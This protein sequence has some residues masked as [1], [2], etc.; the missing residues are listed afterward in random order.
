[1]KRPRHLLL[2]AALVVAAVSRL[3][4]D[5]SASLKGDPSHPAAAAWV[6]TELY[7]GIGLADPA[8]GAAG[9]IT[10]ADWRQFRT[11]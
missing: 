7:F 9:R 8:P 2:L 4:A 11:G 5:G 6:R 10:E 1:M 3:S